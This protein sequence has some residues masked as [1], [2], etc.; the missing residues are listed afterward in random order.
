MDPT[1]T[2]EGHACQECRR[3]RQAGGRAGGQQGREPP[4][5]ED[6][7]TG[8]DMEGGGGKYH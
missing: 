4:A 7:G 2:N 5:D 3:A 6:S 1:Y 8:D